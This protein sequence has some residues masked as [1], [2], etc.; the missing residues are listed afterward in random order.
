VARPLSLLALI[1]G[2]LALLASQASAATPQISSTWVGEVTATSANLRT[3][4]NPGAQAT[5]YRFD[6]ITLAAYE[7]NVGAAK[8]PF[9]GAAKAPSSGSASAGSGSLLVERTQHVAGL[10]PSTLY[11]FRA[12]ATNPS[13]T[14]TGPTRTLGT[15]APTNAFALLDNRGWE[16]VSPVDKNGGAIQPPETIFGGGAFQAAADGQSLTYSSAD[17]FAGAQG[18]P[19]GSQYIATRNAAG[20]TTQNITP[21]LHSGG[22]G[23][24]PDGVPYRL[25]SEDL[26]RGLMAEP[27]RCAG[28][29]C[30]RG[31]SLREGGTLAELLAA[32]GLRLEGASLDLR[33][34][35]L[36]SPAGLREWSQGGLVNLS[37]STEARLAAPIGAIS[38]DGNRVYWT[39]GGGLHLREEAQSKQVD[40]TQGGGGS[41]QTA[42]T[43]GR[44][45]FFT[46]TEHLYRYDAL[47]NV[48]TD[49]TPTGTLK[50][51]LGAS[52]DGSKV[53]YLTT[54]GLFLWS[55]GTTTQVAPG[56]DA[57]LASDYP[58]ATATTRVSADGAHLLFLSAAELSGY[59]ADGRVEAFLYGPPPSGGP[60]KLTC[61]S[62]NPTGERPE[63][64]ASFP[65]TIAN[66]TTR[67]HRPR[68]L[69]AS[70]NRAFFE[71]SDDLVPQDSSNRQDVYEWEA[72]G[73]G[74]CAKEGGCVQLIS[75][76]RSDE[77]SSF[78]DASANGSDAFFLTDSSLAFGDPGSFDLYVAREGGGFPSPPGSIP[79]FGDACQPLP[80]APDDPTPGTVVANGGNPARRFVKPTEQRQGKP[81]KGKGKRGGKNKKG[82]NKKRQGKRKGGKR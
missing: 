34:L 61:I 11:R 20:W 69:S 26:A 59:E 68:A 78:I 58:P 73:E 35:V 19:P 54:T 17:S 38:A 9:T 15:E 49:L 43:D 32:P 60:A 74:S 57:A 50:G 81:K 64:S 51:V 46:K 10:A 40:E 27:N 47:A 48:A 63:G 23:D 66:G 3:Q 39:Q 75:S 82:K 31:Y 5:T 62:C 25:F 2:G 80:E 77:P 28:E 33:H 70:G 7:A 71:S 79:C 29:T 65:G 42:S 72:Q 6:Y 41:F 76:G 30:E 18:A 52:E 21:P 14:A 55:A 36:S 22:Y 56:A 16:M 37:A 1:A 4:I 12:V 44:Y 24:R 67:A 13:G 53:Y 8:D 45:G